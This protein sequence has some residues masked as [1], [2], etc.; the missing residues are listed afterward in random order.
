MQPIARKAD[1]MNPTRR[2]EIGARA[3]ATKRN[4]VYRPRERQ[5]QLTDIPALEIEQAG[6]SELIDQDQV[7]EPPPS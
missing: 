1:A 2:P 3:A 6:C 4:L 5:R 7:M